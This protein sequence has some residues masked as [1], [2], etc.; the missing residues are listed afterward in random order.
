MN[1]N[2]IRIEEFVRG[3]F[4]FE[5]EVSHIMVHNECMG[6][7]NGLNV[8]GFRGYLDELYFKYQLE[9]DLLLSGKLKENKKEIERRTTFIVKLIEGALT[10]KEFNAQNQYKVIRE[11]SISDIK[12]I[13][14]D[15]P[16]GKNKIEAYGDFI[17]FLQK[18]NALHLTHYPN[19]QPNVGFAAPR[20]HKECFTWLKKNKYINCDYPEFKNV[21]TGKFSGKESEMINWVGPKSGFRYFIDQLTDSSK[22]R[23]N[24]PQSRVTA[25][26]CF[27]I[28]G[29]IV[30]NRQISDFP[31]KVSKSVQKIIDTAINLLCSPSPT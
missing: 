16:C 21:F 9:L 17:G 10:P 22:D 15:P 29:Q 27:K 13:I 11:F 14:T 4:S 5:D 24:D 23:I 3:G 31:K 20:A 6:M 1:Q 26:K 12:Y 19:Q 28:K 25:S 18:L 8:S 7:V 2:W 30:T